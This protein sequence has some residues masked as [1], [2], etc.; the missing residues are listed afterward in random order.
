MLDQGRHPDPKSFI[1]LG[2]RLKYTHNKSQQS[3]G[4]FH[5]LLGVGKQLFLIFDV[6]LVAFVGIPWGQAWSVVPT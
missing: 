3:A 4:M 5:V 6:S 2:G 1:V